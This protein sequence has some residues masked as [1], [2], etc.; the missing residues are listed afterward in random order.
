MSTTTNNKP[1]RTLIRTTATATT[2]I[3]TSGSSA[4]VS[5]LRTANNYAKVLEYGSQVDVL[6]ALDER[7][8]FLKSYSEKHNITIEQVKELLA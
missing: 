8:D 6:E 4:V 5:V 1:I 2:D 7:E 3:L